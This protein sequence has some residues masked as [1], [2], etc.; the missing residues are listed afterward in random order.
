MHSVVIV[1]AGPVGLWL[2]AELR[3]RAVPVI[4]LEQRESISP[5]SKALTIHP[6]TLEIFAQRGLAEPVLA[7]GPRVPT[8]HFGGLEQRL[9][10]SALDTAFPFTLL[11]PQARTEQLLEDHVLALGVD[12]RRGHR[13][14]AIDIGVDGVTVQVET[15]DD[16]YSVETAY[17]V[18]CD[19]SG[20]TVRKAAGIGFPGTSATLYGMLGDVILDAPPQGVVTHSGPTG[21]L[22]IVPM[23]GGI[24]RIVGIDPARSE[25][26]DRDLTFEE[27]RESVVAVV[28]SD[29]AMHSPQWISRF[30][31]AARLAERYRLGRVQLAGDAAHMHFPAGGVGMNVGIQDAHA[32]GWRLAD[33]VAGWA[34]DTIL[35]DYASERRAIGADL[36]RDTQAQTV[37]LAAFLPDARELR[38]LMNELIA[39]DPQL[40]RL[41]AERLSGLAVA[42]PAKAGAH[43]LVGHRIITE[44]ADAATRAGAA[45]LSVSS[46]IGATLAAEAA[47]VG[48]VTASR[49]DGPAILVRPDGYVAW[50]ADNPAEAEVLAAVR[51]FRTAPTLDA[52]A[53]S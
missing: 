37:L 38:G 25:P 1:G 45:V 14:T 13:V 20:S 46:E 12:M 3:L 53:S 22:M 10:F 8:G 48:I 39:A 6:R 9:D 44:E 23:A 19:G 32:L 26:M 42:Y 11:Q 21:Q 15:V 16:S 49:T 52:V 27:F 47:A 28:G 41:L 43:S 40:S 51:S 35:D 2:A 50:A 18:G 30:G 29:Y 5:H 34:D 24:H 31:N 36:L 7:G 33:V 17:L 4:V